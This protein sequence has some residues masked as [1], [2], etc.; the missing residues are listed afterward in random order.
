MSCITIALTV[1]SPGIGR[2]RAPRVESAHDRIRTV[3]VSPAGP[4]LA[5]HATNSRQCTIGNTFL[6]GF[7]V[8]TGFLLCDAVCSNSF[9]DDLEPPPGTQNCYN[10]VATLRTN[11][12][13]FDLQ[14]DRPS[15]FETKTGSNECRSKTAC[16]ESLSTPEDKL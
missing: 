5:T 11:S 7:L 14:Q 15:D 8:D 13:S 6:C 10:A 1:V 9:A 2:I 12:E 3:G 4:A 16:P